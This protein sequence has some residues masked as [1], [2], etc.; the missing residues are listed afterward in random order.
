ML[1]KIAESIEP[2]KIENY[3]DNVYVVS[4]EALEQFKKVANELKQIAPKAKDFLYFSTVM[5]TAAEASLYDENGNRLKDASGKDLDAHWEKNGR[6]WKWVCSDPKVMPY[7]NNNCFIAGTKIMMSD[8]SVKNIEDI[9]V[10]DEVITHK[11][12]SRRVLELS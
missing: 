9:K 2:I 3:E 1:L 10:G 7:K 4:D 12:R 6:S 8:G 5:M 11:N